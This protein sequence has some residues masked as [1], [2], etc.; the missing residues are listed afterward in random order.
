MQRLE[1]FPRI[2]YDTNCLVY[3][4][5]EVNIPDSNPKRTVRADLTERTK[6]ITEILKSKGKKITT[7]QAAYWELQGCVYTAVIRE[8]E[9]PG[10]KEML[11]IPQNTPIREQTKLH[12]QSTV[13]RHVKKLQSAT[14]LVVDSQ[15]K[16]SQAAFTSLREF[17]NSIPAEELGNSEKASAVDIQL[18]N[19]GAVQ[20]I[21]LIT[22]DGGIYRFTTRLQ[23]KGLAFRIY[24]L[25]QLVPFS[26]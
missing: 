10:V 9:K 6:I 16:A 21:P 8:M 25:T 15:F 26:N 18:I 1:E 22:H 3:Y 7:I 2:A 12:I 23:A 14:W 19:F 17:F 4:C 11:G 20:R 13:E 5:F 24:G